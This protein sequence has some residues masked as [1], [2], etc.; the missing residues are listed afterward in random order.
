MRI[1]ALCLVVVACGTGTPQSPDPANRTSVRIENR[2]SLDMDIDVRR[3]D[4][5]ASRLGFVPGGETATFALAPAIT[6]GAAWVRFEA[7]PA[8][9]SGDP[10]VSEP[11]QVRSGEQINWSVPPQ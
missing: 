1:A 4:G 9:A 2:A 8:R 6:T 7:R 5:R 10:I 3:N 11:F